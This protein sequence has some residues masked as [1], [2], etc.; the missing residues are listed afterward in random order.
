MSIVQR[1]EEV[2]VEQVIETLKTNPESWS[3]IFQNSESIVFA[4]GDYRFTRLSDRFDCVMML[5][6]KHDKIKLNWTACDPLIS[7]I[8]SDLV[9]HHLKVSMVQR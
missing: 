5:S 9:R 6:S 2:K 1:R 7:R 4:W 3:V 8:Y